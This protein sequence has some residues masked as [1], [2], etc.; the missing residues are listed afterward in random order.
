MELRVDYVWLGGQRGIIMRPVEEMRRPTMAAVYAAALAVF[1]TE[2]E[3]EEGLFK[4]L[5]K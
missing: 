3:K 2:E 4:R 1:K 5:K